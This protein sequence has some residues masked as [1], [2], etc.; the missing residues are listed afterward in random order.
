MII[1]YID[2]DY[3]FYNFED[4]LVNIIKNY[5][6]NNNCLLLGHVRLFNKIFV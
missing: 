6:H 3:Y 5:E 2:H 1:D 4:I